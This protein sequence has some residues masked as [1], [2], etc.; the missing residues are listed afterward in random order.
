MLPGHCCCN[1][2][3]AVQQQ[4]LHMECNNE[5]LGVLVEELVMPDCKLQ[6]KTGL[7]VCQWKCWPR[8]CRYLY[9]PIKLITAFP[10]VFC[11][12]WEG[13]HIMMPN[14]PSTTPTILCSYYN[15]LHFSLWP[16]QRSYISAWSSNNQCVFFKTEVDTVTH[17]AT[18]GICLRR[19]PD[20]ISVGWM[21][22]CVHLSAPLCRGSPGIQTQHLYCFA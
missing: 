11:F 21:V 12:I 2:K 10:W 9:M 19:N 13:L 22:V 7:L 15:L 17:P 3:L 20:V 8:T 14:L 1:T 16:M 18:H 5:Q 6:F 4:E